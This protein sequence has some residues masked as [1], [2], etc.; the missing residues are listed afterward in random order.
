ME[1]D[2]PGLRGRG[3]AQSQA[4]VSRVAHGLSG[5]EAKLN[6]KSGIDTRVHSDVNK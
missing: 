2:E 5:E 1:G 4:S 6:V 3:E